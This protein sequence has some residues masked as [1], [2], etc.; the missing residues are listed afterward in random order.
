MQY[1]SSLKTRYANVSGRKFKSISSVII[2]RNQNYKSD[3][4]L[5]S[6]AFQVTSSFQRLDSGESHDLFRFVTTS[7][8]T[9]TTDIDKHDSLHHNAFRVS[10]KASDK[11]PPATPSL[12]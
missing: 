9:N 3:N 2:Y 8:S 7:I 12:S 11:F 6:H 1:A 5:A 4:C 10:I